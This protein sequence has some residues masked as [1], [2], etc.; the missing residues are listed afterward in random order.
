MLRFYCHL[1][2]YCRIHL[3]LMMLCACVIEVGK[4]GPWEIDWFKCPECSSLN[5]VSRSEGLEGNA[6]NGTYV[7]EEGW[8]VT[9]Y[10]KLGL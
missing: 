4:P 7:V 8:R 10:G 1:S 9:S 5:E 3:L 2:K 6:L